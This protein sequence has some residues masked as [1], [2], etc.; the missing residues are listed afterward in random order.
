MASQ[1]W[2]FTSAWRFSV[3]CHKSQ[4][5]FK[6]LCFIVIY[7]PS[8]CFNPLYSCW[9]L[10]WGLK[11]NFEHFITQSFDSHSRGNYVRLWLGCWWSLANDWL[12][13][14][15]F[16]DKQ[17]M[18][19]WECVLPDTLQNVHI[20]HNSFAQDVKYEHLMKFYII[21]LYYIITIQYNFI[22]PNHESYWHCLPW[23]V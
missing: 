23:T 6:N 22:H 7:T 19:I 2:C 17:T 10:F 11:V 1:F 12:V 5:I 14:R 18:S 4:F 16:Q 3:H 13:R 21:N 20:Y 9:L 8:M 15:L